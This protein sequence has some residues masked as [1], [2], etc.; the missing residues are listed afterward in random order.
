M[1]LHVVTR[2]EAGSDAMRQYVEKK[3]VVLSRYF[4]RITRMDVV[5]EPEGSVHRV[6]I[7]AHL[8]NKKVVKAVAEAGDMLSSLDQAVDKMQRQLVQF[9]ERL[10][11]VR[12]SG[13]SPNVERTPLRKTIVEEDDYLR[14]PVSVEE[15]AE[16]LEARGREFLVF[17]EAETEQP[18]VVYKR[19]DG[20][21]GLIRPHR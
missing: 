2:Y 6:Q 8:V 4:D 3:V 19:K 16:E 12:K 7:T 20:K 10:R 5:L 17:F 14:T 15:A 21:Y 18:A 1:D 13:D 9:K 11:G